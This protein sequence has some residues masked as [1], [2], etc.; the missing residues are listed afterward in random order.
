[1][2][3]TELLMKM[4]SLGKDETVHRRQEITSPTAILKYCCLCPKFPSLLSKFYF[5]PEGLYIYVRPKT[6]C[7]SGF[8]EINRKS[9]K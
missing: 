8:L 5:A 2:Y 3:I 6:Q 9:R 7:P 4:L 1:M